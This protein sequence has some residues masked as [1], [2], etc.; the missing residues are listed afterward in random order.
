MSVQTFVRAG[1]DS[2]PAR[3]QK[4]ARTCQPERYQKSTF[5]A[6]GDH[7]GLALSL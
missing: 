6:E 7:V 3:A 2:P 1:R 5:P 4:S